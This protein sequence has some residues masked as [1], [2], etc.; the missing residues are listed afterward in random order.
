MKFEVHRATDGKHKYR[1]TFTR[2]D[3][4][5]KSVSFG[6]A[7]YSD[8]TQHRSTARQRLYRLRHQA[9]ENWNDPETAGA[10]SWHLLWKGPNFASNV[11]DFRNRF[12]LSTL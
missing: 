6:A 3:G 10:L 12:N 5:T 2:E 8:F 11:A 1:A 4:T 7:G 9:T